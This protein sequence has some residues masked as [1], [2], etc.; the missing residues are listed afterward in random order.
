MR[1]TVFQNLIPVLVV[2]L[3]TGII[4]A[5]AAV[6]DEVIHACFNID[7]RNDVTTEE[8]LTLR[9]IS[10]GAGMY[11]GTGRW[12][13]ILDTIEVGDEDIDFDIVVTASALV[14]EDGSIELTMV[15]SDFERTGA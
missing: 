2:F 11:I 6:Q 7:D 5:H 9:L 10:L 15:G 1:S 4:P 13:F 3:F 12:S 8:F 14:K